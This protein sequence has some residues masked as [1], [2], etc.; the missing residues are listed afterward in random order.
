MP[1]PKNTPDRAALAAAVLLCLVVIALCEIAP[2]FSQ[3]VQLV[4][5]GF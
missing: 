3:G 1:A 4:Y 2:A 5:Q